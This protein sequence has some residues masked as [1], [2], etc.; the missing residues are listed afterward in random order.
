VGCSALPL[1]RM[2]EQR[3]LFITTGAL[4]THKTQRQYGAERLRNYLFSLSAAPVGHAKPPLEKEILC[5]RF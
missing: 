5:P 2:L 1:F 3:V 4:A